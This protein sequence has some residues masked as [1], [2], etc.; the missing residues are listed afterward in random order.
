MEIFLF[1]ILFSDIGKFRA[2]EAAEHALHHR[3]QR[4]V[5]KRIVDDLKQIHKHV[6]AR[7]LP[8]SRYVRARDGNARLVQI[9]DYCLYA[10]ASF[11]AEQSYVS[12]LYLSSDG[13]SV[14][15]ITYFLFSYQRRDLFCYVA[16][17]FARAVVL[18]GLVFTHAVNAVA[19]FLSRF[20][21]LRKQRANPYDRL[22]AAYNRLFVRIE[23]SGAR[24]VDS[25]VFPCHYL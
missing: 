18:F 17:L 4:N 23:H 14:R 5:L 10:L 11:S 15:V 12:V 1:R 13:F 6:D 22:V 21:L 25:A 9:F 7:V 8:V 24:I 16:R 3:D 19:A 2:V 20:F